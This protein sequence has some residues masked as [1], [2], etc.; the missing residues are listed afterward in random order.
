MTLPVHP[1][2]MNPRGALQGGVIAT[3]VDV[4]A[5]RVA[6]HLAGEG[7]TAPTADMHIR[8][9]APITVGPALAI[10]RLLRRGKSLILVQVDVHDAARDVLAVTSTL[11]FSILT[12]RPGQEVSVSVVGSFPHRA[13]RRRGPRTRLEPALQLGG[14]VRRWR[15]VAGRRGR[16]VVPDD[17]LSGPAA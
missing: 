8:F 16:S 2:V 4:A 11:A 6:H 14:P 7:K 12:A 17:A 1:G 13:R 5:G 9:L 10:A 15:A 3:L